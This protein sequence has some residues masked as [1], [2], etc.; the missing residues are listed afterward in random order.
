M[1]ETEIIETKR[2][3][4]LG[5]KHLLGNKP[6]WLIVIQAEKGYIATEY[7]NAEYA[8]EIGDC[9]AIVSGANDFNEMLTRK[10]IWASRE[11]KKLGIKPGMLGADAL[12]RLI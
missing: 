5:Y 6:P 4:A 1:I 8:D 2:G 3:A 9:C 10:I 7:I 11:A 12:E